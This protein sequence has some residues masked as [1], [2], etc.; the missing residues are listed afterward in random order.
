[1]FKEHF[2]YLYK[3]EKEGILILTIHPDVTGH[4]QG[5]TRFRKLL[6]YIKS[7]DNVEFV[8]LKEA[9]KLFKEGKLK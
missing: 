7:H 1:M 2:N 5:L 9:A 6:E 8:T 3:V 4:V